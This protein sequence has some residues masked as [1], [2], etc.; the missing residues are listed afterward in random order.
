MLAIVWAGSQ[1]TK[2]ARVAGA[3]FLAPVINRFLNVVQ[4]RLSLQS[5]GQAAGAVV[6]GLVGFTFLVFGSLILSGAG[7]PA[8]TTKALMVMSQ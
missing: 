8:L 7:G 5:P 4:T 3:I 2:A 1:V 6:S